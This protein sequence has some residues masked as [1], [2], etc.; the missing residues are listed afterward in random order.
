MA[1]LL[2]FYM[3]F[4]KLYKQLSNYSNLLSAHSNWRI[5]ETDAEFS[6]CSNKLIFRIFYLHTV[7]F[8]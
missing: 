3:C 4:N 6:F 2:L 7:H 1:I 5:E 8:D